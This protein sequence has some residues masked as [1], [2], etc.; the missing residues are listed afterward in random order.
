[1]SSEACFIIPKCVM[2]GLRGAHEGSFFFFFFFVMLKYYKK[3]SYL[4]RRLEAETKEN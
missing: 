2:G 1:M 3:I 4:W